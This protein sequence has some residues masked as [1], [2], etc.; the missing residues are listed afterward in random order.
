ML[1]ATTAKEI[2]Y[3]RFS[4]MQ[5][6]AVAPFSNSFYNENTG[7]FQNLSL[8]I[9]GIAIRENVF[10]KKI[11]DESDL[12]TEIIK[13]VL[14]FS[15]IFI[16]ILIITAIIIF[17]IANRALLPIR[18]LNKKVKTLMISNADFDF[19][20]NQK[21][22]TSKELYD[23][24]EWISELIT[25][26]RFTRNDFIKQDDTI[27]IMG[28]ADAYTVLD[29]NLQARGICLTNIAH[30]Y[31]KNKDYIKA[32]K[33]YKEAADWAKEIFTQA[34]ENM[35]FKIF[36]KN[37]YLYCKRKYYF[38]VWSFHKVKEMNSDNKSEEFE[39]LEALITSTKDLLK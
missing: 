37:V 32:A 30:I 21:N 14:I 24:Y 31:Y 4:E 13:W 20:A 8:F 16:L 15:A 7:K 17:K 12:L 38:A 3:S 1:N 39:K 6:A 2:S 25:A 29:T 35:D 19:E 34:K 36:K 33:S 9:A 22:I 18:W 10:Q 28:F 26:R 5:V 27:A 11:L 23:I